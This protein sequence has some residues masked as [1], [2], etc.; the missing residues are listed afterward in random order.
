M[1]CRFH[2]LAA[3]ALLAGALISAPAPALAQQTPDWMR[4]IEDLMAVR[5]TS[6]GRKEQGCLRR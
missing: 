4:D 3:T 6:A 5:V 2:P 1:A